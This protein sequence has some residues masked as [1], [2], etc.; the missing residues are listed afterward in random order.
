[1]YGNYARLHNRRKFPEH[2][3]KDYSL[4]DAITSS[5]Q[6][7]ALARI[8]SSVASCI[9]WATKMRWASVMPSAFDCVSAA[10]S[11]SIEAKLTDGIP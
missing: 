11:N 5:I 9:G 6:A 7:S 10:S 4:S 8:S 2:V 1:M 3:A